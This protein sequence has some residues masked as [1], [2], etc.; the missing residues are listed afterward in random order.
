[1][2]IAE[3][4]TKLQTDINNSYDAIEKNGGVVP[5]NKNTEN[6]ESAIE[7]MSIGNSVYITLTNNSSTPDYDRIINPSNWNTSRV[8]NMKHLFYNSGLSGVLDL[9]NF[10]TSNVTSVDQMFYGCS[11][12]TSINVSSFNT[13]KVTNFNYMFSG[14]TSLTVL[15]VSNFDTSNA[16]SV[17]GMF[18]SCSKLTD[19]DLSDLDFSKVNTMDNPVLNGCYALTNLKSFKNLGKGYTRQTNNYSRYQVNLSSCTKLTHDSLMS[20]INNLYDLNLTYD[21]ANDGTLYTQQLILGSTNLAK[22]TSSEIAIATNKG[23][24]VS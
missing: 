21:V 13:S 1:M 16:T 23:W 2:S 17:S 22:L 11:G 12:L 10:N 3:K 15:D 24:T 8:T 7:S 20:V 14:C 6:L 18:G 4:I 9:S 19:L 5:E